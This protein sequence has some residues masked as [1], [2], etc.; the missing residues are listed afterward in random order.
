MRN[1]SIG[2]TL[3]IVVA[4]IVA[5]LFLIPQTQ[6][7]YRNV[8]YNSGRISAQWEFADQIEQTLGTDLLAGESQQVMYSVKS[9]SV[10]IVDRNGVKTLRTIR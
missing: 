3:G 7:S 1:I 9:S 5:W 10:V 8:G 6:A 2:F 4:S